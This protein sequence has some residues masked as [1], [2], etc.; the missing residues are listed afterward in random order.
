MKLIFPL[1]LAALAFVAT[2][3]PQKIHYQAVAVGA[4]GKPI[5]NS[6]V[7]LRLSVLDSLP[8]GTSLYTETQTAST[9]AAGQFS[10]YLG[11]GT[12]T[13]GTFANLPWANGNDKFLKV[14]MDAQ[15]GS[16]YQPMGAT[17]LVSMPYAM[18]AGSLR[19]GALL[20]GNNGQKYQLTIDST[21]PK[22]TCFPP[23][24]L[25]SAGSDQLNV[26][27]SSVNLAGNT[28][29]NGSSNWSIISGVGG[30]FGNSNSSSTT[31]NGVLGNSYSLR[32]SITNACGSSADTVMLSL[33]PTTTLS[34]AGP[35]Q[36][37]ISGTT[38]TLAANTPATG[39][40]G[41]WSILTGSGGSLNSN[42][43]PSATFT[44]G[45]DSA[46]TLV[47]TITG[48]C[49]ISRDTVILSF[50]SLVMNIP[51]PGIPTVTYGGESY[52]TVQIGN[53]CWLAKNMNVGNYIF[54]S[55][56][57]TNN[58]TI[59]KYCYNNL[60]QNCIDFGG[61]YQWA[62]AMQYPPCATNN[63]NGCYSGS[64]QGI[65]PNGWH[66]PSLSEWC[67]LSAFLDT[68]SC[69]SWRDIVGEKLKSNSWQWNHSPFGLIG[70][71]ITGFSALPGGINDF[72][73]MFSFG[74][75]S[76]SSQ[77]AAGFWTADSFTN[78]APYIELGNNYSI[79]K[80]IDT[81]KVNAKSV[82]CLKD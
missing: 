16:N 74:A 19:E 14:E 38:A 62:E 30:S 73:N 60:T 1:L 10:I 78:Q 8:T 3:Q 42:S 15:G 65:C 9:D 13:A 7:G 18:A 55:N 58:A 36:L 48:P 52:P 20:Y 32:Y 11:G 75:N 26:C 47:W 66:I 21:G 76:P 54:A 27:A 59:E 79:L 71:N 64:I 35:D 45:T 63:T 33:A 57:Q 29:S 24:T 4:N 6:T 49:G 31:F 53:Q 50:Q 41:A 43:N 28:P 51:C 40:T 5:K 25:A 22:W 72:P 70:S 37:S 46:Y 80:R 77:K 12:A 39:E 82:R 67:T 81:G 44:K 2:A 68:N 61:L 34:N 17:Q 56:L 69:L 23:V